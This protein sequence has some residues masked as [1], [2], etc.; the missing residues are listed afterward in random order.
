MYPVGYYD[1][2]TSGVPV[3]S[4]AFRPL[5]H[6]ALAI[7]PF[8]VFTSL[9]R[10][11]LIADT[12]LRAECLA[13]LSKRKIFHPDLVPLLIK[14]ERQ[15][16][17][18]R[19]DADALVEYALETFRWHER[20]LVCRETYARMRKA[21]PLLADI[22]GFRGPHINHLTPRVLDID[23]AQM[24]MAQRGYVHRCPRLRMI[25]EIIAY[26]PKILSK[27]LPVVSA[28]SCYAKLPSRR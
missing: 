19:S 24:G 9:L 4:T 16:G 6:S 2:S 3:H 21:H 11:D 28:L 26:H 17:L 23:A 15:G 7:N 20:S 27:V 13:I 18:G 5:S 1:L 22:A 10:P 12:Y 8:R 14:A 25:A